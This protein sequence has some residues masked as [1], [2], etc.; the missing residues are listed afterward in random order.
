METQ[1]TSASVVYNERFGL[2]T[3][4][5]FVLMLRTTVLSRAAPKASASRLAP[6]CPDGALAYVY[7]HIYIG[8]YIRGLSPIPHGHVPGLSCPCVAVVMLLT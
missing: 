1:H 8:I 5:A 7:M 6:M 4:R 3:V 2:L